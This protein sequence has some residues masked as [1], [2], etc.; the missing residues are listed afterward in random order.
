MENLEK[1]GE[2]LKPYTDT[3]RRVEATLESLEGNAQIL[4]DNVLKIIPVTIEAEP[5][6]PI[7]NHD[8][9]TDNLIAI[10]VKIS[11]TSDMIYKIA[12]TLNSIL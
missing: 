10:N 3:L 6:E 11:K 9:F 4:L 12:K 5:I 1:S 8:V 2:K 7:E